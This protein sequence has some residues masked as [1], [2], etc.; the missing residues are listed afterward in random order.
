MTRVWS[1]GR[2]TGTSKVSSCFGI[3]GPSPFARRGPFPSTVN[4]T[5]GRRSS[6]LHQDPAFGGQGS[7]RREPFSK[8]AFRPWFATVRL[9]G[10]ARTD[11][12]LGNDEITL[13][14]SLGN[15]H[16]S[17]FDNDR[18]L[19]THWKAP[20]CHGARGK[21]SFAATERGAAPEGRVLAGAPPRRPGSSLKPPNGMVTLGGFAA[22]D[23]A[24]IGAAMLVL[25][26]GIWPC[27]RCLT[28]VGSSQW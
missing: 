6:R 18:L 8:A 25:S 15:L 13:V 22:F 27:G 11:Q 26:E 9:P 28:V 23:L 12:I 2:I 14:Y 5:C 7:G 24:I 4:L 1:R 21:Q 17:A 10:S 3:Q 16:R 20:P 19:C